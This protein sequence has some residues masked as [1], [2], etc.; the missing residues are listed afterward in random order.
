MPPHA[1]NN[2]FTNSSGKKQPLLF[3]GT[4]TS[5]V[6]P[7]TH[8]DQ[9]DEP[10]FLQ[11]IDRQL[12]AGVDSLVVLGT[13]GEESNVSRH[14]RRRLVEIT[15]DRVAGQVPVIIGTGTQSTQGSVELSREA[16]AAGA[17]MLML[18]TPYYNRPTF[19]GLRAH[20]GAVANAVT[21]PL[22]LYHV[23]HRTGLS[24]TADEFLRLAT[25]IPTL[26]AIKDASGRLSFVSEIIAGRPDGLGVYSGDEEFTLPLLV[27]GGDGLISV[28][29][30]LAPRATRKLICRALD[31]DWTAAR[32]TH[33]QLLNAMRAC[34]AVTNPIPIKAALAEADLIS[35]VLRLP[36][37]PLGKMGGGTWLPSLTS[38]TE[39]L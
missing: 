10:T 3:R 7:F 18:V 5:L 32:E 37:Q 23:P 27:L 24:L 38:L 35:P 25:E 21:L 31:G 8:D 28:L 29:S 39:T 15:L 30:N 16:A 20:L 11:L 22:M 36:L 14:E 13:T 4:C 17:N 9:I 33:F 1:E 26:R 2:Q 6:T 34:F 19:D 12:G